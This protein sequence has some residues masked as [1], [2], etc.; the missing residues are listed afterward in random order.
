MLQVIIPE[1][2]IYSEISEE[3]VKVESVALQLEHSLI[4]LSAWESKW[5]K[6]F[7]KNENKTLEETYDYIRC[8]CLTRNIPDSVFKYIPDDIYKQVMD[9][10]NSKMTATWFTDRPGTPVNREVITA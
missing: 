4:S 7:L 8:M 10:I 2:E 9:Y 3:F 5:E 6:P 1:R